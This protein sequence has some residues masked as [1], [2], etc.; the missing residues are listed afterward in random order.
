MSDTDGFAPIRAVAALLS[1]LPVPWFVCGGW[2]IDC[3]LGRVTREHKDVD[4]GIARADQLAVQAYLQARGWT[5]EEAHD[6]RLTLWATGEYLTLPLHVVW[7][8]NAA[9]TPDFVELLLN[10][11][12]GETFAFRRDQMITLPLARAMLRTPDGLPYLAPELALLYKSGH[13]TLE[14]NARDFVTTLSALNTERREWLQSALA[15]TRA[16]HPW[17]ASFR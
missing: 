12:A 15:R 1:E 6:G 16:D 7:G 13:P 4:I 14:E 5:L 2:A 3:F 10:E 8:R 11:I 17:L 9:Y